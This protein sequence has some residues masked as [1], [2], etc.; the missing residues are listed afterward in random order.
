MQNAALATLALTL[1][2]QSADDL[3][4]RFLIADANILTSYRLTL[5][6]ADVLVRSDI[7]EFDVPRAR[8]GGLNLVFAGLLF[9]TMRFTKCSR[10]PKR[11]S[12]PLIRRV[13]HSRPA[14]RE[15]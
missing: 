6:A 4:R 5:D 8:D 2:L 1:G 15:I 3:A 12:S 7:G 13:A 9:P 14:G 10:S 11:P